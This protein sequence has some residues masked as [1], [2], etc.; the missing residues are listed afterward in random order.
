MKY[1]CISESFRILSQPADRLVRAPQKTLLIVL[2]MN[3]EKNINP[4]PAF[5]L[6]TDGL[7]P[8]EHLNTNT[9]Y[10]EKCDSADEALILS[11]ISEA[12]QAGLGRIEI[13]MDLGNLLAPTPRLISIINLITSASP[14]TV[15]ISVWRKDGWLPSDISILAIF[16]KNTTA[17]IAIRLTRNENEKAYYSRPYISETW[18]A[19]SLSVLGSIWGYS[20]LSPFFE[21][22]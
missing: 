18:F 1:S 14:K 7:R 2:G 22:H 20:R 15:M 3:N 16:L 6:N 11:L 9:V 5:F 13:L 19:Y 8:H 12:R 17:P 4:R 21:G 10:V